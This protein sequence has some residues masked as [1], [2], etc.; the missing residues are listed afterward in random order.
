MAEVIISRRVLYETLISGKSKKLF[1][2][3]YGEDA[4]AYLKSECGYEDLSSKTQF[5]K[6][7]KERWEKAIRR[8]DRFE[9]IN[10][11]WLDT[12][13]KSGYFFTYQYS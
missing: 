11:K 5:L 10:Q 8:S 1:S 9:N 13:I 6:Q 12:Q 3:L 4:K 2:D 7:F